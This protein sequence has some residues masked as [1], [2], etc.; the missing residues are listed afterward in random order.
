M[1][2]CR[3]SFNYTPKKWNTVLP[4][5]PDSFPLTFATT[6]RATKAGTGLL[7]H[8]CSMLWTSPAPL[9]PPALHSSPS[10]KQP[11]KSCTSSLASL[12]RPHSLD[13]SPTRVYPAGVSRSHTQTQAS[14]TPCPGHT[15]MP[16]VRSLPLCALCNLLQSPL[17]RR[18]VACVLS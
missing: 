15:S 4:S 7:Q 1:K 18:A 8:P 11:P 12:M 3:K 14:P 10:L 13:T 9:P 17:H 6:S 2:G 16:P 5:T